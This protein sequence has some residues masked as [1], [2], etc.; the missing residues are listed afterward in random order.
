[1]SIFKKKK[2][3]NLIFHLKKVK[4]RQAKPK[5][6]WEKEIIKIRVYMNEIEN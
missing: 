3:L 6:N 1:M 2:D 5:T 4:E